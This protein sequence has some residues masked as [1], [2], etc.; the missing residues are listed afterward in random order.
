MANT[1]IKSYTVIFIFYFKLFY[2]ITWVKIKGKYNMFIDT[3]LNTQ[4]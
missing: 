1:S 2:L 4:L 3:Y